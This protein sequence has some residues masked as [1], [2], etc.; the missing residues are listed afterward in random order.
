MQQAVGAKDDLRVERAAEPAPSGLLLPFVEAL[1]HP[2]FRL[3]WFT[4]LFGVVTRGGR[5]RPESMNELGTRSGQGSRQEL[6]V[7]LRHPS[8][9]QER[10][11]RGIRSAV[12]V[13]VTLDGVE[14]SSATA[15]LAVRPSISMTA[16]CD[17]RSDRT[18]VCRKSFT[19]LYWN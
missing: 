2:V 5:R 15:D 12:R 16:V 13:A 6:S 10:R 4:G 11:S 7:G 8:S 19:S 14:L 9:K 1:A 17:S 18:A 3:V